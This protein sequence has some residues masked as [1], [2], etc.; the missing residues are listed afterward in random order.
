MKIDAHN[1]DRRV[2]TPYTYHSR[3]IFW[4]WFKKQF[5]Q[6]VKTKHR[7]NYFV[8]KNKKAAAL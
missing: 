5:L 2:S 8:Y 4:I 6:K 1:I 3:K 7:H